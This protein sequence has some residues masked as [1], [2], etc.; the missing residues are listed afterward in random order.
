MTWLPHFYFSNNERKRIDMPEVI[1]V[2]K[3]G[4]GG[5]ASFSSN[6]NAIND[7]KDDKKSLLFIQLQLL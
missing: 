4:R 1:G 2:A 5:I 6:L 7:I 3:G